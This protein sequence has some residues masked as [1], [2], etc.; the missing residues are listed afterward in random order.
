MRICCTQLESMRRQSDH[1]D[2]ELA[3]IKSVMLSIM[4]E[5]CL[6]TGKLESIKEALCQITSILLC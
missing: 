1:L 2:P 5:G 4:L 6:S 3:Q